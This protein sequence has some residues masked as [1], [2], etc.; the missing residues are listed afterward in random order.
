MVT[1]ARITNKATADGIRLTSDPADPAIFFDSDPTS[2][3]VRVTNNPADPAYRSSSEASDYT[4]SGPLPLL[5]VQQKSVQL[6][7]TGTCGITITLD[8]PP[9]PGNKLVLTVAQRDGAPI[10]PAAADFTEWQP[11]AGSANENVWAGWRDAILGDDAVFTVDPHGHD[12]RAILSEWQGL[13]PGAPTDTALSQT[14]TGVGDITCGT[15]TATGGG[16]V[17]SVTAGAMQFGEGA[18]VP[19]A[20]WTAFAGMI[21]C[22]NVDPYNVTLYQ[23]VGVAG[24]Y[25]PHWDGGWQGGGTITSGVAYWPAG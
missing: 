9:T 1:H 5:L 22:E 14:D 19:V 3:P 13:A 6:R 24:D 17:I 23:L 12:S 18:V 15:V 10:A 4:G 21:A 25:T 11:S 7:Q 16:L 2:D 20:G 8:A